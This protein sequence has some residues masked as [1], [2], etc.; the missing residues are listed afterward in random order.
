[1]DDKLGRDL[2]RHLSIIWKAV[3]ISLVPILAHQLGI[4]LGLLRSKQSIKTASLIPEHAGLK[5][6]KS[7]T[8]LTRRRGSIN[9]RLPI[10]DLSLVAFHWQQ[11]LLG[12]HSTDLVS[13]QDGKLLRGELAPR[14]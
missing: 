9:C 7:Q 1:M 11:D 4:I 8:R 6:W 10:G 2:S 14:L 13:R 3:K 5:L 12:R